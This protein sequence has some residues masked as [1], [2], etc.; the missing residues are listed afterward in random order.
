MCNDDVTLIYNNPIQVLLSTL[1]LFQEY[2]NLLN[3]KH[4][5]LE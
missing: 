3:S 5:E 4:R 2:T 1:L